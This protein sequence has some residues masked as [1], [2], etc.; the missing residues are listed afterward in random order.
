MDETALIFFIEQR[1][2]CRAGGE[3][4]G[5]KNIINSEPVLFQKVDTAEESL[6]VVDITADKNLFSV[7]QGKVIHGANQRLSCFSSPA[8]VNV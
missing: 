7:A 2:W 5:R 3:I 8:A 1:Y 4:V 6:L